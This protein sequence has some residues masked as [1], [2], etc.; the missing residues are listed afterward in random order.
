MSE[1]GNE[2]RGKTPPPDQ[3][4]DNQ[5]EQQTDKPERTPDRGGEDGD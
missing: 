5:K 4:D 2:D 1:Y 3:D